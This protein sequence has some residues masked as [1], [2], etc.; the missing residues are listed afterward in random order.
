LPKLRAKPTVPVTLTFEIKRTALLLLTVALGACSTV[1]FDH[2]KTESYAITDVGNS[3]LGEVNSDWIAEHENRSGFY[4]LIDGLDALGARLRMIDLAEHSIDAQYFLMKGDSAGEVFAG[5]LLEAADRGVRVRF[6]LDDVFT[7][8]KDNELA[9]LHQHKNIEVRLFNPVSRRGIYYL[10]YA[11]DFRRANR[12]MHNKSFTA[13][14]SV[15]VVGGRNIADEYFQLKSDGI[16]LDF[17]MLVVGPVVQDVSEQFDEFWNHPLAVPMDGLEQRI[18]EDDLEQARLEINEEL[19]KQEDSVYYR[20]VN[21]PHMLE[22]V[23][24]NGNVFPADAFLLKDAPEKFNQ[25]TKNTDGFLVNDLARIISEAESSVVI[26]N[27]YFIPRLSGM[28]FWKS[29]LDKG[30]KV[31]VITNSLAST[32][33]IPVHSAYSRYRKPML[34]AGAEIYEIRANASTAPSYNTEDEPEAL[35]LHTK[36]IVIDEKR[37]FVGSLNLDPRS[38]NINS[39][40]GLIIDS[41]E[42]AGKFLLELEEDIESLAYQLKLNEKN[43]LQWRTSIDDQ[44]VTANKEP[45]SS[46][47]RRFLA[48]I[49]K[50]LPEGQL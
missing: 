15:T 45:L 29:I 50:L 19:Q 48:Q 21:T 43:K 40:M 33:H 37:L 22:L 27:P 12:R 35:T 20:A 16:F 2:P 38:I 32:N 5:R 47:W 25:S 10:N 41:E 13:D 49:Y 44:P 7:T 26:I 6:L 11:G 9:L 30:V 8:V 39:E 28:E 17:D 46:G 42:M 14:N 18:T 36:L 3:E 24:G 34:N 1:N 31:T 4:P 23:N